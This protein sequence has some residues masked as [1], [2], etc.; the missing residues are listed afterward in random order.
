MLYDNKLGTGEE[1]GEGLELLKKQ[2]REIGYEI[3]VSR[4]DFPN[5]NETPADTANSVTL[6]I[7]KREG[8]SYVSCGF[9]ES[10][11]IYQP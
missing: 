4:G 8:K 11:R 5:K 10:G 2:M 6:Q 7:R 9:N 1:S 3:V